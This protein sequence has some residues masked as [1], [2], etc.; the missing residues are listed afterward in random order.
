MSACRRLRRGIAFPSSALVGT[1]KQA[2]HLLQK[3]PVR[4]KQAPMAR[5]A[6]VSLAGS[7]VGGQLGQA[8]ALAGSL[9]AELEAGPRWLEHCR[10][11]RMRSS[12]LPGVLGST[13]LRVVLC[14]SGRPRWG[15]VAAGGGSVHVHR[16][17]RDSG[18]RSLQGGGACRGLD[19]NGS[20]RISYDALAVSGQSFSAGELPDRRVQARRFRRGARR[21]D[22][23]LADR[24]RGH[25]APVRGREELQRAAG[26]FS[27]PP[28]GGDGA[29]G[30]RPDLRDRSVCAA[31]KPARGGPHRD[32]D[33][34]ILHGG[35]RRAR[36]TADGF[37]PAEP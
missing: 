18:V 34:S 8:L 11:P 28:V 14:D 10:S 19:A 21:I 22:R 15:L 7:S 35:A 9:Q 6:K 17:V 37:L 16:P 3:F 32:G 27:R 26:H 24:I 20:N 30:A 33:L 13:T 2:V 12:R 23:I 36:G 25:R 5:H 4:G 1:A 29:G 31:G